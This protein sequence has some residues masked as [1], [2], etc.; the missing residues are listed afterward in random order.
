MKEV[1]ILKNGQW[2]TVMNMYSRSKIPFYFFISFDKSQAI[3][4]TLDQL[5]SSI[6]ISMPDQNK[7]IDGSTDPI[8]I[9]TNIQPLPFHDYNKGFDIVKA[10]LKGGD[11]FLINLTYP[12]RIELDMSLE[13]IFEN[14][15][16]KYKMYWED[17]CVIFSPECFIKIKSGKVY[18]YPMKGTIDASQVNAI[19][20]L[21]NDEKEISEHY[22]IVDLI[23]NDLSM[24]AT[25]VQ[26][27]KYRYL[28]T[29]KSENRNL[30]HTSSIVKGNLKSI[31]LEDLGSLFDQ[32]L[33]AGSISGA[34]KRKTLEIIKKAE[35]DDR[36]FYTGV[37]GV[38]DGQDLD[39]G[40]AIRYI[41]K[42]GDEYL[43]RSGGGITNQSIAIHEYDELINKIYVPVS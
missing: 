15:V 7:R 31:F 24:I 21:M 28:D 26:V 14:A 9:I 34:P 1:E 37:F 16:A 27:E 32:I 23:R 19:Y 30:H 2:Q 4:S 25:N 42:N 40:V 43:Y 5:P 33:P 3:V 10:H 11:T 18:S 12:S 13:E 22:T 41:E 17:K 8:K 35:L 36:G 38:Y 20:R 6:K 29:I 39:S